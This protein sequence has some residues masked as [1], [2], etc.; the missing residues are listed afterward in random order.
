V[1]DAEDR[2]VNCIRERTD[3]MSHGSL[4][5]HTITD[6]EGFRSLRAEWAS[7]CSRSN[8]SHLFSSFDWWLNAWLFYAEPL[9]QKLR[10]VTG[11]HDG[12]LLLVWPLV[13]DRRTLRM[14]STGMFEYRDVIVEPSGF[15]GQWVRQAWSYVQSSVDADVFIF[16]NLRMPSALATELRQQPAASPIG[17]GWC[18]LI[19][20]DRFADWDAYAATLPRSLIADQ[21]RQWKRMSRDM[22]GISFQVID[23]EDELERVME[24]IRRHKI[25]W[26]EARQL[27]PGWCITVRK[28]ENLRRA[29]S[30]ALAEGRLIAVALRDGDRIV[31]A[32]WGF[33]CG[34]EYLFHAFSYD[35]ACST[36]SPSRLL[37]ERLVRT[38]FDRGI[39]SF[40][41]MP[42]ERPFKRTWATDYVPTESYVGPLNWRGA[43]LLR[44]AKMKPLSGSV[45]E[46]VRPL[47]RRLP[48]PA[49]D[50]LRYVL[51]ALSMV[52]DAGAL[53][54]PAPPPTEVTPAPEGSRDGLDDPVNPPGGGSR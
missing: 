3:R 52:T 32:G 49:R 47:Y 7:L 15:A 34:D 37:L 27:V 24:W 17:G 4:E 42:G 18:P 20:L 29:A 39:R 53:Q 54:P 45:A 25:A 44:L 22:P 10:L 5:F 1:D 26:A 30:M 23:C 12:R 16:Q 8:R 35:A 33:I 41:F 2:D 40:D 31:S 9:G 43:C 46:T 48:R 50:K 13:T 28:W 38:C 11:R 36:Y 21:R 51:G 6:S 19:R 14:L